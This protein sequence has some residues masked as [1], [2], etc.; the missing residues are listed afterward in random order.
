MNKSLKMTGAAFFAAVLTACGGLFSACASSGRSSTE[1]VRD[2]KSAGES[3]TGFDECGGGMTE[4]DE[5]AQDTEQTQQ[6]PYYAEFYADGV[7]VSRIFLLNGQL[8]D[9]EPIVPQKRGYTGKWEEYRLV[10]GENAIIEAE[11]RLVSYSVDYHTYGGE[12]AAENPRTYTVETPAFTFAEPT[13]QGYAFCGWYADD[14][15]GRK[16]DG[17]TEHSVG[18]ISLYAKWEIIEYSLTYETAGGKNASE[19]PS[20]YTVEGETVALFPAEREGYEFI[21]WFA[22]GQEI[23]EIP[24]GST[25][26]IV[27]TAQW[28]AEETGETEQ[29]SVYAV[30]SGELTADALYFVFGVGD[31][32]LSVEDNVIYASGCTGEIYRASDKARQ[33]EAECGEAVGVI[34]AEDLVDG[35]NV[36]YLIV[37]K[38][39]GGTSRTYTV[40]VYKQYY[41][42]VS[43]YCDGTLL[44]QKQVLA[45]EEFIPSC[46]VSETGGK[47]K[48]WKYGSGARQGEEIV[49]GEKIV[50]TE[51]TMLCAVI[52]QTVSAG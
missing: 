7:R 52:E 16:I 37:Q 10:A 30:K 6:A 33:G 31:T 18:N 40:Y 12:N 29:P 15:F 32:S 27:L 8:T 49:A 35:E 51:D 42:T 22:N 19:N 38:E 34:S 39:D 11:Y 44:A 21:G 5:S 9:E 14:A 48:G 2:S 41:V 20:S 26:D 43:Y 36:F 28:R 25:G 17:I 1:I 50:L 3:E 23:Y 46:D 4:A 24:A 13:R 45:D 47:L